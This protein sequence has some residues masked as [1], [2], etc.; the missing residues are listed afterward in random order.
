MGIR[1]RVV[2]QSAAISR[3]DLLGQE[4]GHSSRICHRRQHL[5]CMVE[6]T[7]PNV[8]SGQPSSADVHRPFMAGQSIVIEIP[9]DT[10]GATQVLF[11]ECH[12]SG[13]TFR[14]RWVT[15]KNSL[16][17]SSIGNTTIIGADIGIELFVE[18]VRF[19][20]RDDP[21]GQR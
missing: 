13:D 1:L 9:V 6:V 3:I 2:T 18:S 15:F 17:H 11:D 20:I 8:S 14:R 12:G 16:Q 10:T 4:I 7:Q 19:D 5:P 21:L